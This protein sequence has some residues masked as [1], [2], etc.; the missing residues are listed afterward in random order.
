MSSAP[1]E[2]P[3]SLVTPKDFRRSIDW[4]RKQPTLPKIIAEIIAREKPPAKK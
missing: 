1:P 4:H 3:W 2:F